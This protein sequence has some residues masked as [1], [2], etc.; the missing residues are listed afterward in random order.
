MFAYPVVLDLVADGAG[1]K[2]E[3]SSLVDDVV[4]M[5]I[6]SAICAVLYFT[7]GIGHWCT[8]LHADK[9]PNFTEFVHKPYPLTP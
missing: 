9:K 2:E 5:Y 8:P 1:E 3:V 4:G 6:S 7:V